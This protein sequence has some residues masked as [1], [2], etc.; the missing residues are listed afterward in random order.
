MMAAGGGSK[1]FLEGYH[2]LLHGPSS[3][4]RPNT[5]AYLIA[6]TRLCEEYMNIGWK[7]GG[8]NLEEI[9]VEEYNSLENRNCIHRYIVAYC[10]CLCS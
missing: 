3:P 6:L 9:E 8:K 1:P 10:Y 5:P 2:G 4:R 7:Y